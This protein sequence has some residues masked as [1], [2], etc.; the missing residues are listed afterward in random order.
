MVLHHRRVPPPSLPHRDNTLRRPSDTPWQGLMA[1][2]TMH[3]TEEYPMKP[4]EVLFVTK[5]YHPNSTAPP[6]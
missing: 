3:F 1:H 5:M 2:L 6:K 4:P